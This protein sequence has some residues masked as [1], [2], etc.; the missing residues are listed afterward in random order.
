[1]VDRSAAVPDDRTRSAVPDYSVPLTESAAAADPYEQFARWYAEAAPRLV[2]PEAMAL[3]TASADGRPSVRMV[4]L[5]HWDT[6]GF[7]FYTNY[8]SLKGRQLEENP[9]AA[10][11]FYWEALGRQ[12]RIDGLVSPV[13]AEESDAY[14]ATRPLGAQIGARASRQS[15]PIASRTL[16]EQRVRAVSHSHAGRSVPRPAWWGGFRVAARSFEF[17]Q[18]RDDRLHDRLAYEPSGGGWRVVR[19]QP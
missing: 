6:R 5:K 10:L 2:M 15:E 16:L 11:L 7:V 4:L 19:L 13:S 18:N 17:W 12:V 8:L 3:A 1:M 14:F 9:R